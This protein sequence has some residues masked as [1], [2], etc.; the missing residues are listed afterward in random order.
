[1]FGKEIRRWAAGFAIVLAPVAHAQQ[2]T[3]TQTL[4]GQVVDEQGAPI[5]GAAIGISLT[6]ATPN[7][8]A[9]L[10]SA[11]C[12]SDA[13]G[14]FTV[15]VPATKDPLQVLAAIRGR[16]ACAIHVSHDA[17][18]PS[19]LE[20]GQ[21]VLPPG[22][23]L[24]GRIRDAEGKPVGGVTMR[25]SSAIPSN[26]FRY[27]AL[28]LSGA[29]SNDRGIFQVPCVPRTGLQLSAKKLGYQTDVR[30]VSHDSPLAITLEAAPMVRGR[31]LDA[32]G[33]PIAN[34]RVAITQEAG[35]S[36]YIT[37]K[38]AKSGSFVLTGPP[39]PTRYRVT[40]SISGTRRRFTT[41]L[42]RGSQDD[43]AF[44]E[45]TVRAASGKSIVVH[46]IDAKT[47]KR[48][49]KFALAVTNRLKRLQTALFFAEGRFTSYELA[50]VVPRTNRTTGVIVIAPGLAFGT[51]TIPDEL[52]GP[53]V[54]ELGPEA[55]ITGRVVDGDQKPVAGVVVRALPDGGTK[56]SGSKIDERWPR[57][58]EQ[59]RYRIGGL[60]PGAYLVQA[61]PPNH[62][63]SEP[64]KIE[65]TLEK[66]TTLE[67][68]IPN[69]HAMTV[70]LIGDRPTGPAPILSVSR[71][72]NNSA[73]GFTHFVQPPQSITLVGK[74]D[75]FTLGTQQSNQVSLEVFLPSRTRVGSGTAI[76]LNNLAIMDGKV[77]V[78]LPALD[79]TIM[80]GR[81]EV[82]AQLP[83]ARLAL[84]ATPVSKNND[85]HFYGVP[86][87]LAGVF[88]DGSFTIDLPH[89][90]Y[91][92]QLIDVETG[93]VFHTEIQDHLANAK[94]LVLRPQLR[95]LEI[96][97][98]PEN[99]GDPVLVHSLTVELD[100]PRGGNHGAFLR[101]GPGNNS[102]ESS[103]VQRRSRATTL[104][105]LVP[106]GKL[107]LYADQAPDKLR[108]HA[109]GFSFRKVAETSVE[110]SKPLHRLVLT[111]PPLP[112]DKE[113]EKPAK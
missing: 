57:T 29:V 76:P 97:L 93:I 82:D 44:E 60:Q 14:E 58:D 110:I 113:L 94:G 72:S 112:S 101:N 21:F 73:R 1:M 54:V 51:A 106:A 83:T 52:A 2:A 5:A 11:K 100:R 7:V 38:T 39:A 63:P 70:K 41:G 36:H 88:S 80:S 37:T 50:A 67:V 28:V 90:E 45:I 92:L 107:K 96:E 53:L 24:I 42:L 62:R 16:Q 84:I 4:A 109:N 20:L 66:Q 105:W 78:Q 59:G 35:T 13:N 55:V 65:V 25:V 23:T 111:L 75:T 22:G 43:V 9:L 18:Q 8:N 34:A 87:V 89:G 102:R 98:K 86:R 61:Y 33:A 95:W 6:T 85:R 12:T 48:I 49:P 108:H 27:G 10:K 103:S 17:A 56:G 19:R 26:R 64:E 71:F 3:A 47:K 104:R 91:V 31:L 74:R 99:A 68:S 46:V 30:I 15:E 79:C 81:I 77:E 40:A 32:Q 69:R